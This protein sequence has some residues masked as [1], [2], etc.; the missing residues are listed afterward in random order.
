[1][2]RACFD[3]ERELYIKLATT[4]Y[5]LSHFSMLVTSTSGNSYIAQFTEYITD[6]AT[7]KHVDF[8]LGDFNKNIFNCGSIKILLQFLG[9]SQA[10]SEAAHIIVFYL[11]QIHTKQAQV[12]LVCYSDQDHKISLHDF[13]FHS[14]KIKIMQ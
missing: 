7:R 13:G 5:N 8:N 4:L 9:F 2:F 6:P 11:N 3:G 14:M 12:K 10:F 1:M